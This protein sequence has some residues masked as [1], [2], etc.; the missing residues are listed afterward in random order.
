MPS[1]IP[2]SDPRARSNPKRT[3]RVGIAVVLVAL[4][5]AFLVAREALRALASAHWPTTAATITDSRVTQESSRPGRES[6]TPRVQYTYAVAGKAYV[7]DVLRLG[8]F[9]S[10]SCRSLAEAQ[11][12]RH[13]KGSTCPVAYDPAQPQ[14]SVL[15]PGLGA[16]TASLGLGAFLDALVLSLGIVVVVQSRRRLQR[17]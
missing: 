4:V 17:G 1:P 3:L 5:G 7:G 8:G 6:W 14:T 10:S 9:P 2:P 15:E 11:Q 16:A 13:P 12:Q